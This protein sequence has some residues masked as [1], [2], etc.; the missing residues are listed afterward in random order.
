MYYDNVFFLLIVGNTYHRLVKDNNMPDFVKDPQVKED[1]PSPSP[2]QYLKE[3]IVDKLKNIDSPTEKVS[4]VSNL[5]SVVGGHSPVGKV[6]SDKDLPP[7]VKLD[8]DDLLTVEIFSGNPTK[9]MTSS[10]EK[11]PIRQDRF[12]P[13]MKEDSHDE[14]VDT[15]ELSSK[16]GLDC[17]KSTQDSVKQSEMNDSGTFSLQSSSSSHDIPSGGT[18]VGHGAVK[19]Q[20]PVGQSTVKQQTHAGNHSNSPDSLSR[21]QA[22]PITT[23][24]EDIAVSV[25]TKKKKKKKTGNYTPQTKYWWYLVITLS[26]CLLVHLST[27]HVNASHPKPF[28]SF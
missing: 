24:C 16:A 17:K 27:Y 20:T 7:V 21:I 9:E 2:L 28:V 19:P 5:A 25:K 26:V 3:N 12:N 18:P 6:M 22:I 23:P 10:T 1:Q 8:S 13:F 11:S 14:E 4:S 15:S